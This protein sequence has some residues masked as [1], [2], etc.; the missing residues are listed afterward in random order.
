MLYSLNRH[1]IR[2]ANPT[3]YQTLT[4]LSFQSKNYWNYPDAYF[5]IWAK[6]LTITRQ[7][8]L[9]NDVYVFDQKSRVTGYYSLVE[10]PCDL[11]LSN[12]TIEAGTWLEHMFVL[13]A[14]VRSGVG[15]KLFS[16]CIHRCKSKHTPVLKILSDPNARLFYEKRGCVF[17][18]DYPSTIKGRTT[19]YL[20]YRL[21]NG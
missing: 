11:M 9:T 8:I 4:N 6:E 1:M 16:H 3:E 5:E 21:K 20:E 13:P 14:Y 2:K 19:P 18:K 10:L 15:T 12:L 17:V 7:Y